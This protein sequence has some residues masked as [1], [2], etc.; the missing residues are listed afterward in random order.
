MHTDAGQG[1][2]ASPKNAMSVRKIRCH[3]EKNNGLE[4]HCPSNSVCDPTL[5]G[6]PTS[7]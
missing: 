3:G 2:A 7:L 1:S 4:S 5:S 6:T